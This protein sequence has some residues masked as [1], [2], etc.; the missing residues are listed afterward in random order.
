MPLLPAL[1]LSSLGAVALV[2]FVDKCLQCR[3]LKTDLQQT[4]FA[5]D[6]SAIVARTDDRGRITFANDRFC[7]VSGYSREELLGA[8]HRIVNS[9]YHPPEFFANLYRTIRGGKV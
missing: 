6:Q 2:V 1:L 4:L 7:E 8:D 5:L 3:R 9:G